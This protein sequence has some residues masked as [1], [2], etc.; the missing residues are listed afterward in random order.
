MTRLLTL[1]VFFSSLVT[2]ASAQIE[3]R[4]T[5]IGGQIFYYNSDIDFSTN[6]PNQKNR[7]ATFN[8]SVGKL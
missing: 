7:S 5:L 6:Q 1:F 3:K 8:I 4:M 2:I